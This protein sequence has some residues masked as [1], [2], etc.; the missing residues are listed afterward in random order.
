VISG[1]ENTTARKLSVFRQADGSSLFLMTSGLRSVRDKALTYFDEFLFD[2]QE[3][4]DRLFKAVNSLSDQIRRVAVEDKDVLEA[5]GLHFNI[6]CLV[7][8][9]LLNDAEPKLYLIYP[10]ANWVEIGQGTPYHIIGSPG[11]GKPVLDRTLKYE[12]SM[13][14]ALKV[15][16]L[17]FDSTRISAA[18]VDFPVDVALYFRETG[19]MT[20]RRFSKE[21]LSEI[22]DGWQDRLRTS[23]SNL[24][25]PRLDRFLAEI[26]PTNGAHPVSEQLL[27]QPTQV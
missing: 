17:A 23:V 15:G 5:S 8:G 4:F 3:P 10:Q 21:D 11:Y 26:S 27:E 18:D 19:Q 12:D 14:F 7:G 9:Q 6:H 20:E 13:R 16:C 22:S 2:H 24:P 25:S 1:N